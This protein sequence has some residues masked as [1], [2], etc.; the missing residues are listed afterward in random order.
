MNLR[1]FPH[2]KDVQWL[3]I[4]RAATISKM[5]HSVLSLLI[6]IFLWIGGHADAKPSAPL[7]VIAPDLIVESLE[8][9]KF[10]SGYGPHDLPPNK[11]KFIPVPRRIV[12]EESYSYGYRIKLKTTRPTVL[13][14]QAFDSWPENPKQKGQG[15]HEKPSAN[16]CIY[17]TWP[18]DGVRNGPRWVKVWVENIELPKLTYTVKFKHQ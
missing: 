6:I 15:R 4:I 11:V 8:F 17:E 12:S 2:V 9:G 7:K 16:G 13:I 5:F 10:P 18:L 14:W 1:N 3:A